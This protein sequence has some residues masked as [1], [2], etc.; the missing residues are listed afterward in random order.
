[1][2][3]ASFL[4]FDLCCS[5]T[6]SYC[7]LTNPAYSK[8]YHREP[9]PPLAVRQHRSLWRWADRPILSSSTAWN[10]AGGVGKVLRSR[11]DAESERRTVFRR[12]V[13]SI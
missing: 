9:R 13:T 10:Q 12:K 8:P 7:I 11:F 5:T 1:M 4:G 3:V 2:Q 6:L